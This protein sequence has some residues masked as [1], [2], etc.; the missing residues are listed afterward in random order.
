MVAALAARGWTRFGWD[1]RTAAWAQAAY[2]AGRR[3]LEDPALSHWY[4]CENTWFVGVD[5]LPNDR[6]GGLGDVPL[7]GA[8]IEAITAGLGPVPDLHRAQLSVIFPGYPKPR[9]GEGEAAFRYR[10]RRDGAHVDGL[11]AEGPDK[12]R[13]LR[14]AHAW[15]L[16]LPLTDSHPGAAPLVVWEGSHL[17]MAKAF[18]KAFGGAQSETWGEIDVTEIYQA[19]RREVFD[20]CER[21]VVH[22][23]PGEAYLVHRLALH[24][25]AP[26]TAPDG[27]GR[28]IAYF[29]P[30]LK[31]QARW[32]TV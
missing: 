16:G 8:A 2:T 28:M 31:D 1:S 26:W 30:K 25:V 11:L 27:P 4:Q 15:I 14:E 22:A 18:A 12:R 21:V 10:L 24:G 3:A 32:A 9:K 7:A 23:K 6:S 20:T 5:A 13:Y 17:I 29:R 19:A